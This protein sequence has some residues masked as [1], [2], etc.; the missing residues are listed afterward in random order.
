MHLQ[1]SSASGIKPIN[2][3]RFPVQMDNDNKTVILQL[4]SHPF[5]DR[6]LINAIAVVKYICFLIFV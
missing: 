4:G 5:K 6:I 3:V 1:A 2:I